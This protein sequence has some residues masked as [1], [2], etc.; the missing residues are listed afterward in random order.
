MEVAPGEVSLRL[1]EEAIGVGDMPGEAA[2]LAQ[3][4]DGV[5]ARIAEHL[6]FVEAVSVLT[7]PLVQV[8]ERR[9]GLIGDLA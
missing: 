1:F 4:G 9:G 6:C 3:L 8:A 5:L 2:E 7:Q